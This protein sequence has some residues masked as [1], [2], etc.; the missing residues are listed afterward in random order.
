MSLSKLSGSLIKMD[1]K[2]SHLLVL[3]V[4]A[5]VGTTSFAQ[6]LKKARPRA[7]CTQLCNERGL[8]QPKFGGKLNKIRE[9][10]A[11]ETDPEKVQ[12]LRQ[13]EKEELERATEKLAEFCEFMC[14]GNPE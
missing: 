2:K 7:E 10:I 5:L 4:A 12:V 6:T 1:I 13:K 11:K 9:E 14:E 3:I 8:T